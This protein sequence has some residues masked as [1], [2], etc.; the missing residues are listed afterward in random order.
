MMG[1]K[2]NRETC[3]AYLFMLTFQ[4]ELNG[5]GAIRTVMSVAHSPL[6]NLMFDISEVATTESRSDL[7]AIRCFDD[8]ICKHASCPIRANSRFTSPLFES[9]DLYMLISTQIASHNVLYIPSLPSLHLS[10]P[11]FHSKTLYADQ[12]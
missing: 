3:I 4:H 1:W 9:A 7:Q 5:V 10:A 11:S 6:P 8:L 2:N 12:L